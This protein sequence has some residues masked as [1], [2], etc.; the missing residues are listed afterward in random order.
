MRKNSKNPLVSVII[1]TYNR[2]D[3]I[4]K[5][6]KSVLNQ[7]YK[8]LE[9]VVV[10]DG[11]EDNTKDIME[12]FRDPRVKYI[13]SPENRGQP[14]AMNIGIKRSQGDF[15]GL[16]D[17]D[18]EYL[19]TKIEESIKVL[20]R[21]DK[22]VGL[23][24]SN[25]WNVGVKSKVWKIGQPRRVDP[26]WHIPSPSTWLLRREVFE[27]I[28]YYDERIRIINDRDF[29]FRFSKKFILEFIDKPL[30]VRYESEDSLS[31]KT[32][33]HVTMRKLFLKSIELAYKK[34]RSF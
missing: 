15:I 14:H 24:G 29:L 16:L 25:Y 7:T 9:V 33:K 20:G 18:D 1:P 12:K 13:R 26:I 17:S 23:V 32:D 8:N 30:V 28:G 11:S 27:E 34:I 10:D 19:P 21:G 3:L 31:A 22:R 2:G 5:A 4:E 6:V